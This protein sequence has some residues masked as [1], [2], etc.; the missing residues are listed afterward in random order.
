MIEVQPVDT[1]FYFNTVTT[2]VGNGTA[3]FNCTAGHLDKLTKISWERVI[4]ET[5]FTINS[6]LTPRYVQFQSHDIGVLQIVQ[7]QQDDFE[8]GYQC[9]IT[10]PRV[11]GKKVSNRARLLPKFIPTGD[12]TFQ[13]TMTPQTVYVN[14]VDTAVLGCATSGGQG[15]V[16]DWIKTTSNGIRRITTGSQTIVADLYEF[17]EII[18]PAN[19]YIKKMEASEVHLSCS[20]YA[21][22]GNPSSLSAIAEIILIE[23]PS[24]RVPLPQSFSRTEGDTNE[25]KLDCDASGV[26]NPDI[27][28]LFNGKRITSGRALMISSFHERNRGMYQCFVESDYGSTHTSTFLNVLFGAKISKGPEDNVVLVGGTVY[29]NCLARANPD[30]IVYTWEKNNQTII[31]G[32]RISMFT[33]GTL[34]IINAT[35][36]DTANY[37]CIA[38]NSLNMSKASATLTVAIFPTVISLNSLTVNESANVSLPCLA[39]GVPKPAI[40]W[41]TVRTRP[42]HLHENGTLFIQSVTAS[43]DGVYICTATNVIGNVQATTQ[44]IVQVAPTTKPSDLDIYV[45]VGSNVT[46]TC[47][48]TSNPKPVVSWYI[49]GQFFSPVTNLMKL[50]SKNEYISTLSIDGIGDK[51]IRDY[52]CIA[53]NL[54]GSSSTT[55]RW[56]KQVVPDM[57]IIHHVEV[58]SQHEINVQWNRPWNGG[59]PI[60]HFIIQYRPSH[61]SNESWVEQT[62]SEQIYTITDLQPQTSYHIQVSAVNAIGTG[63]SGVTNATTKPSPRTS[64]TPKVV[65]SMT[66]T[67]F[68]LITE[69]AAL[70]DGAAT[71]GIIVGVLIAVLV[72]V[73]VVVI[74]LVVVLRRKQGHYCVTESALPGHEALSGSPEKP[75]LTEMTGSPKKVG[76]DQLFHETKVETQDNNNAT[77]PEPLQTVLKEEKEMTSESK[78]PVTVDPAAES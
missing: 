44:L 3:A 38:S 55:F 21:T 72:V 69:A 11:L 15:V 46:M 31:N 78:L 10:N 39:D 28:W 57:T 63:E 30:D 73:A 2:A 51:D 59:T 35:L 71:T 37:S 33:N 34:S 27:T 60:K 1:Y 76:N 17:F 14:N 68:H 56:I 52:Q 20:P 23:K 32:T 65:V 8:G 66:T 42:T 24:I 64:P 13:F 19:L 58:L 41:T 29:F 75:Q 25:M 4:G 12:V 7:P 47:S 70:S 77:V 16:V 62:T 45:R 26:P 22:V 74:F 50:P 5:S 43:D 54:L 9:V 40:H 48:I 6:T 67:A 49:G 36:Q 61:I 53:R 18:K